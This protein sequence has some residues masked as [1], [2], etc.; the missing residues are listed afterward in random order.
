VSVVSDWLAA[1]F[2]CWA[3]EVAQ[4]DNTK[5]TAMSKALADAAVIAEFNEFIKRSSVKVLGSFSGFEL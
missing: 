5:A 2:E 1:A 3:D 4:P